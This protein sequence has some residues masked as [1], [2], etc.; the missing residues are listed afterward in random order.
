M[1]VSEQNPIQVKYVD[2]DPDAVSL[3]LRVRARSEVWLPAF[4]E[5][6]GGVHGA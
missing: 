4:Q 2:P 3:P 6:A 1:T 5:D